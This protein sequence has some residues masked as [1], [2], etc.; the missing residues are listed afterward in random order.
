M[1]HYFDLFIYFELFT[2]A[3]KTRWQLI[4]ICF[5]K[6]HKWVEVRAFPSRILKSFQLL[7]FLQI[8]INP[9]RKQKSFTEAQPPFPSSP[10]YSSFFVRNWGNI[11][12]TICQKQ[13]FKN[14]NCFLFGELLWHLGSMV[15]HEHSWR[16]PFGSLM[17]SGREKQIKKTF[18]GAMNWKAVVK[19]KYKLRPNSIHCEKYFAMTCWYHDTAMW[20]YS[21][22][23]AVPCVQRISQSRGVDPLQ[24]LPWQ[25]Y[26]NS[27]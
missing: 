17:E 26:H 10:F 22:I 25:G 20:H 7:S 1:S 16:A 4:L 9:E 19:D 18:G 23:V 27:I 2:K 8:N 5:H 21:E 14:V 24:T 11:V 3:R 15:L 6:H 13:T 12:G